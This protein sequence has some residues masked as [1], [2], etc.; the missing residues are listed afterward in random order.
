MSPLALHFELLA[1]L[2]SIGEMGQ[3]NLFKNK[4]F[5]EKMTCKYT[6]Q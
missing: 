6:F 5:Y 3:R 4:Q 2:S 1:I